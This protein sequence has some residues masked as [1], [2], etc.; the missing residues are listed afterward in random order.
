M[1]D[2]SYTE[3]VHLGDEYTAVNMN[4]EWH[5]HF[6]LVTFMPFIVCVFPLRQKISENDSVRK[7][8]THINTDEQLICKWGRDYKSMFLQL[9][10]NKSKYLSNII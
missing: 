8:M 10:H 4:S 6:R 1:L 5:V 7:E 2:M 9:Q 3:H